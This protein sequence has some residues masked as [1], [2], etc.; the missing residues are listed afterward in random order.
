MNDKQV[1]IWE[2]LYRRAQLSEE[3]DDES[4][5]KQP[6]ANIDGS[7]VPGVVYTCLIQ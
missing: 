2:V 5:A 6:Q 4:R 3:S 7:L 1:L